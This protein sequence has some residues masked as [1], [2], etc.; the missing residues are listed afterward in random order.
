MPQQESL[1]LLQQ[2]HQC[3]A[4]CVPSGNNMQVSHISLVMPFTMCLKCNNSNTLNHSFLANDEPLKILKQALTTWKKKTNRDDKLGEGHGRNCR[5]ERERQGFSKIRLLK[6]FE[7]LR[8]TL[9]RCICK[10]L[11]SEGLASSIG[12]CLRVKGDVS[13]KFWNPHTNVNLHSAQCEAR[14]SVFLV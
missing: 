7:V 2:A 3:Q 9:N 13:R 4:F 14:L 6:N 1:P 8:N 5:G 11:K 10:Q 12:N